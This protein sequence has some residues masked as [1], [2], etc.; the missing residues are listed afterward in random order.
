MWDIIRFKVPESKIQ[1]LELQKIH[2][3]REVFNKYVI[4]LLEVYAQETD[5]E[6]RV[7]IEW[8]ITQMRVVQK[9]LKKISLESAYSMTAIN[10]LTCVYFNSLWKYIENIENPKNGQEYEK[11][12]NFHFIQAIYHWDRWDDTQ[13]YKQKAI[14]SYKSAGFIERDWSDI[15]KL[16][17][18]MAYVLP[19][20]L[21]ELQWFH[22]E[23]NKKIRFRIIK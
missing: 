3:Q 23:N 18:E 7:V 11:S 13:W 14:N 12:W 22:F 6:R 19:D 4:S 1:Q 10:T 15:Q 5:Q 21:P 2:I 8:E 20:I 17:I 16:Y 9:I